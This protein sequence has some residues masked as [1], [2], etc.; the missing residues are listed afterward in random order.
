VKHSSWST[1]PVEVQ[2]TVHIFKIEDCAKVIYDIV[3]SSQQLDG[4]AKQKTQS[5]SESI[6]YIIHLE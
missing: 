5:S 2:P 1:I 4:N 6:S 3:I